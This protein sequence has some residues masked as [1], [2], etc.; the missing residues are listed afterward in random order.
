[1]RTAEEP[2]WDELMHVHHYLGFQG[3]I[4]ESQ[5]SPSLL[6]SAKHLRERP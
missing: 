3:M 1:M 2:I 5:V 6:S 4:R